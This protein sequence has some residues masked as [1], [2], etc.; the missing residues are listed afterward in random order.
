MREDHPLTPY[1]VVL[2]FCGQVLQQAPDANLLRYLRDD[3]LFTN[4]PLSLNDEESLNALK[5][6]IETCETEEAE[7]LELHFDHLRLFSGPE[8]KAV[9]WE[10]VW[11]EKDR[12]LFG[13]QT[14]A[15]RTFYH[16]HGL[17]TDATGREPED[18][19]GLELA[20]VAHLLRQAI[21]TGDAQHSEAAR[22]FLDAH[23]LPWADDCLRRAASE[24]QTPFYQG[25]SLLCASALRGL[26]QALPPLE[27]LQR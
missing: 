17:T 18:H 2:L 11:R 24:A 20:F 16:S 26:D 8:P 23:V 5:T 15:V 1:V 10:S 12:L 6:L 25:V 14:M 9:P 27:A 21:N 22:R 13:E 19:L 7:A 4:W 3:K